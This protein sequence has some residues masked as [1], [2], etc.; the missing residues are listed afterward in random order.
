MCAAG[1]RSFVHDFSTLPQKTIPIAFSPP[2]LLFSIYIYILFSSF[3]TS[4]L[5]FCWCVDAIAAPAQ[6]RVANRG[7]FEVCV[8]ACVPVCSCACV[9]VM[10]SREKHCTE[11]SFFLSFPSIGRCD[12]LHHLQSVTLPVWSYSHVCSAVP[13]C[14]TCF[15]WPC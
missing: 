5:Q 8:R 1:F 4:R 12:P 9:C 10:H 13:R 2:C 15:S 11:M 3:Q 7:W 6:R 14:V